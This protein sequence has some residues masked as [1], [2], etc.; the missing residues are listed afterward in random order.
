L[1][2]EDGT[3]VLRHLERLHNV[4]LRVL[5]APLQAASAR[6]EAW[7]AITVLGSPPAKDPSP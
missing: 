4:A 5:S 6:Q 1:A 3:I 7:I 2:E